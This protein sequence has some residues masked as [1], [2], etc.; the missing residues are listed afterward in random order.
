MA[1]AVK[2]SSPES[3]EFELTLDDNGDLAS[4]GDDEAPQVKSK[5]GADE[6]DIFETDFEVPALDDSD[7]ATVADSELESSDFD[8]A[9]DDSELA[10]EDESGSQVVALDEDSENEIPTEGD[11]ASSDDVEVEAESGEFSALDE[12]VQ[13]EEEEGADVDVDEEESGRP[14]RTQTVTKLM[15]PAPWGVMPVIFM[16]PCVIVMMLVGILGY[17]LVQ[18][19]ANAK[20]PGPLTVMLAESFGQSVTLKK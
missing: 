1:V 4:V 9:L 11:E 5:K 20:P 16:L 6:Q 7:D 18:S 2:R 17:E 12:D 3:S 8:L 19:S 15:P 14:V 10:Q 13:V